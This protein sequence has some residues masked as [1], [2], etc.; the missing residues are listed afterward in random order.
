MV[1]PLWRLAYLTVVE[2]RAFKTRL[3][4][5]GAGEAGLTILEAIRTEAP[6]LYEVLGFIDDDPARKGAL[7]EGVKVLGS[8]GDVR[9]LGLMIGVEFVKDRKTKIPAEELTNRVVDLAFERGL[10]LL[11]CG[12]SI[13]R[14][15][16]PLCITKAEIDEGLKVLDE[17]I[18]LAEKEMK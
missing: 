6:Q 4:I 3:L 7:Y 9:G 17:A 10:V 2:R 1:L 15:A 8:I 18:A 14:V 13:I 16:P 11:S 5:V 12:K